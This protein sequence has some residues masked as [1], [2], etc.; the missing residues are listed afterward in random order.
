MTA[1]PGGYQV[2]AVGVSAHGSHPEQGEN[3]IGRLVCYLD[4][5]PLEGDAK[6]A[7]HFLAEKL[8]TDP[9][10]SVCWAT[11]WRTRSPAP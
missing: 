8:G 11:G 5:L 3:A 1:I 7:V 2:E 10:A 4:R 6:Q 9:T